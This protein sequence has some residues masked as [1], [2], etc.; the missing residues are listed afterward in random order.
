MVNGSQSNMYFTPVDRWS[1]VK[2]NGTIAELQE[3]TSGYTSWSQDSNGELHDLQ[4]GNCA[5]EQTGGSNSYMLEDTCNGNNW[6]EY[7][8]IAWGY[9]SDPYP[10]VNGTF[11][12]Y[13]PAGPGY[14]LDDH[15]N[16]RSNGN[17]VDIAPY[18]GT[19]AQFWYV[20]PYGSSNGI[21]TYEFQLAAS[22]PKMCLDK[23]LGR[24]GN[25]TALEIWQCNGG[26]NQQWNMST[27]LTSLNV[28][29]GTCLDAPL[30][31]FNNPV[32]DVWD[33]NGGLNQDWGAPYYP[34][35]E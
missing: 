23:P 20:V 26:P 31:N 35:F 24:N 12:P 2:W 15:G 28:E 29:S 8:D 9:G 16:N 13:W 5:I 1:A 10:Y 32:V 27:V 18:N 3:S 7:F 25:G 33:C 21:P 11:T 19:S 6:L 14:V 17:P 4:T 22:S 34:Y 30:L